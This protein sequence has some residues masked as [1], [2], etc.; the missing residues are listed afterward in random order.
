M[1]N[2]DLH[3]NVKCSRAISPGAIL[4]GDGT[5]TSQ[6]IDRQGFGSLEFVFISGV[7]TDGTFTVHVYAGDASDMSD[8]AEVTDASLLL[9]VA[10]VFVATDDNVVKKVGYIGGKRYART[11]V[12]QSGSTTGGY[13][14]AVAVQGGA[15]IAPAA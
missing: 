4:S 1:N 3:N 15:G 10:P 7:I 11:K 13:L 6:T 2:K 8:E 12:V 14:S 9:G 5:T